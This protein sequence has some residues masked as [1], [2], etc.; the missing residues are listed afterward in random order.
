MSARMIRL[1]WWD[2][3]MILSRAAKRPQNVAH[4]VSRG[5]ETKP[6]QAPKGGGRVRFFRPFRA[7]PISDLHP[8][9]T[10]WATFLRRFASVFHS[11]PKYI[12]SANQKW[13][14]VNQLQR[15]LYLPR[16]SRGL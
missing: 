12:N 10:P 11:T 7:P 5:F 13:N 14:S 15:K 16:R 9:L 4:G 3:L 8:G 2:R 1:L 6:E